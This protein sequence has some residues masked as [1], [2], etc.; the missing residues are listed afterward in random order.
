MPAPHFEQKLFEQAREA[1]ERETGQRVR[2]IARSITLD[3]GRE[4]DGIIQL[5]GQD[6]QLAMELKRWLAQANLGVLINQIRQLPMEG[7]LV[8]DYVNPVMAKRLKQENIQFFDAAGN[9]YLNQPPVYIYVT[10]NKSSEPARA[11][12]RTSRAFDATGLK[13]V[14]GFLCDP[15]LINKPYRE[16]ATQTCVA[17][18][19]VGWI[20]NDLR[21]AGLLIERAGTKDR[22]LVNKQ[23]L[24][25]RWV[26][27]YPEKLKPKLLVG[28]FFAQDPVWWKELDIA[29]YGAYWS[30]EVAAAKYTG[31][32]APQ[33]TTVYLPEVAGNKLL[34]DA[35]LRRLAEGDLGNK[36]GVVQIYRPFWSPQLS[37]AAGDKMIEGVVNPLLVYADLIATGEARNIETAEKIYEQFIAQ[38]F[39]ED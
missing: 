16:I 17:L 27:A 39:R 18:G 28:H 38:Y 37:Q 35:K 14:F 1:L 25:N 32:L 6:K 30:G 8:A 9:V 19:T 21:E 5:P 11:A 15:D 3:G 12:K 13:V 23:K 24:L 31:Y 20:L 26:E 22:R 7:V 4:F 34:A 10:G 29:E 36:P 33:V 2:L